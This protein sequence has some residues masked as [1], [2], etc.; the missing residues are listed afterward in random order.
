MTNVGQRLAAIRGG[1]TAS[2]HNARTIAALTTNPGCARRAVLDCAGVD[3]QRLAAYIDYPARFG[4]SQFAITRGNAFEAQVKA[5]GCAQL[6]QLLRERLDLEI[7]EVSYDDLESVAGRESQDVRYARSRALLTRAAAQVDGAGTLFDHPLLRLEVA[8]QQAYLEPDLIAF[9]HDGQFH[10]VEIKSFAV[11]DGQGDPGKVA[12]AA[13]QAAVYVLAMRELLGEAGYDPQVVSHDVVLVCPRDFSNQPM[14]VR[15]DVRKQLAV[16][17]RQLSRMTR[18]DALLA[19]LPATLSFDFAPDERGV[20]TRSPASL[21]AAL[22]AVE[23]RY[24]PECLASCELAYFCRHEARGCTAALG[25]SARDE[26]GG[27]ERV[28]TALAIARS[29]LAPAE[30]QQEAAELLR[31]AARLR[32]ELMSGVAK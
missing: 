31:A 1:G 8:G 23:A 27:I 18:I 24:S 15:V 13:I 16:L 14:A 22:E 21:V 2:R 10:V 30:D 5:N 3:K 26:V 12:A 9:Q 28:E 11:I 7:P 32:A 29:Q 4:Q 19:D 6:L 17:R 20:P 25:K